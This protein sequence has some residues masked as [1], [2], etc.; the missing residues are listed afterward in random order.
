VDGQYSGSQ[1][2]IKQ[3]EG[4]CGFHRPKYSLYQRSIFGP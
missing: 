1:E 4:V 2:E 3:V